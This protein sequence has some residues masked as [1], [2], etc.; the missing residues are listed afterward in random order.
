MNILERTGL[1]SWLSDGD[2]DAGLVGA[3]NGGGAGKEAA[4][5]CRILTSTRC[6]T[7]GV[8]VPALDAMVNKIDLNHSKPDKIAIIDP[9]ASA[10]ANGGEGGASPPSVVQGAFDLDSLGQWKEAIYARL[11]QKVGSR[12]YREQWAKD[13]ARIAERHRMRL[14]ERVA[15][16]RVTEELEGF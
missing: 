2:R 4:T 10:G 14:A 15:D 1:L 7:E 9:F 6:L 8:D 12:Q 13:V 3:R 11:V 16:P 5:G